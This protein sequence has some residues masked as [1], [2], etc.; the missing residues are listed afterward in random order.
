MTYAEHSWHAH[1]VTAR[2][3]SRVALLAGPFRSRRD[4]EAVEQDCRAIVRRDYPL[5]MAATF[6][7]IGT[8]RVTLHPGQAARPGKLNARLGLPS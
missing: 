8:T 4:A 5:D 3:D 1:Y 2:S 7:G 6:A